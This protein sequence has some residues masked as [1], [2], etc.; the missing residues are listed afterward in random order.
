MFIRKMLRGNTLFVN[1]VRPYYSD[2]LR[3]IWPLFTRPAIGLFGLPNDLRNIV[4]LNQL[5]SRLNGQ[6]RMTLQSCA[7]PS[8]RAASQRVH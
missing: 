8:G 7:L 1:N 4:V 5:P 6:V 2:H 3:I